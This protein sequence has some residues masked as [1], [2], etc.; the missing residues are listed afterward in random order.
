[1]GGLPAL[2]IVLDLTPY[3]RRI[4]IDEF[5]AQKEKEEQAIR[6]ARKKT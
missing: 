2:P 3:M 6:N 1:M 5:I 4:W